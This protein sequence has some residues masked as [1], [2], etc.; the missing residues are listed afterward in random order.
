MGLFSWKCRNCN[1]AIASR[2][3]FTDTT[4]AWMQ[5]AIV[6]DKS[7]HPLIWGHYDGY[8]RIDC[9]L[10]DRLV[11]FDRG[12]YIEHCYQDEKFS[13][14]YHPEI[15]HLDCYL[16]R[17]AQ[18]SRGPSKNAEC[19]GGFTESLPDSSRPQRH[20]VI[21]AWRTTAE[22]VHTELGLDSLEEASDLLATSSYE[23][24]VIIGNL[25]AEGDDKEELF[26]F[27]YTSHAAAKLCGIHPELMSWAAQQGER[28]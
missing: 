2:S 6:L 28:P 18:E 1:G 23:F 10:T 9:A 15:Y 21:W 11:E 13:S 26:G 3:D 14:V 24:G 22:V 27:H 12:N 5:D 7:G 16:E 25:T 17:G 8:G 20:P 19:Q 4:T